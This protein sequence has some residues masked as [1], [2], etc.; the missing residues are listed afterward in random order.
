MGLESKYFRH[1]FYYD[2]ARVERFIEIIKNPESSSRRQQAFKNVVFK[3]MKDVVKKNMRNYLNLLTN[4]TSIPKDEIPTEDELVAD[5]YLIFDKCLTKYKLGCGY[6][7]Y[8][9]FNKSMSR[10]F[11][12]AWTKEMSRDNSSV[13]IG[14]ALETVNRRFHTSADSTS[15]SMNLLLDSFDFTT[16][17]RRVIKSRLAGQKTGEFLKANSD[18]THNQY[19]QALKNVKVR[20]QE[21]KL[22]GEI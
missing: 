12:R 7:F 17:E 9:Y 21:Y 19:S 20:I 16:L 2:N 10:C 4:G 3:M 15:N 6:N 1:D 13:E 14:E 5:C 11:Y 18:V 8:F 22:M